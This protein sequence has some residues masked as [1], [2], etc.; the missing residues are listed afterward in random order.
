M[1]IDFF[2]MQGL[3][4]DFILL[5]NFNQERLKI[6]KSR[7]VKLCRR[8]FG[9]GADGILEILSPEDGN[10]NDCR[11]IIYNADGSQAEM[12]GNGIRCVSHYLKT[13]DIVSS[14]SQ[15]I[16]T[17]AGII[18]PEILKLKSDNSRAEVRVNLGQPEFA[19]E[20]IPVDWDGGL[21]G[22]IIS[23]NLKVQGRSF[24]VTAVSMGNP[25]AVIFI[26]EDP[27]EF[28]LEKWGPL[29][30]NH[31]SFP[32][33]TNVEI[34]RVLSREE[35]KLRVWE[36]GSG[37]TLACGTGAAATLAAAVKNDLT[38]KKAEVNLPGGRLKVSWQKQNI[39]I[40]G[41]SKI[42]YRGEINLD[43]LE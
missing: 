14:S 38:D 28:S 20:E 33:K 22:E 36:R 42:V 34:A 1:K 32:E 15:R 3:G 12:C 8:H 23:K 10:L 35:I 19:S 17:G 31:S 27:D 26:Q 25:H 18:K 6:E 2:K 11:V 16:E 43:Y 13:S 9:I 37:L 7:I 4:N 5:D 40:T 24:T 29:L 41:P 39:F 30:E 21:S